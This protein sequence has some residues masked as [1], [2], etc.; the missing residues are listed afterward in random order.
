[1]SLRRALA[2]ALGAL[3]AG[4]AFAQVLAPQYPGG[5]K[6]QFDEDKP[7]EEQRSSLPAYPADRDLVRFEVGPTSAFD[8]FVD[9]TSVSVGK[10]GVVRYTLVARSPSGALNVSYEG[11]RCDARQRKLYAFG[12]SDKTWAQ[13]RNA[14]GVHIPDLQSAPGNHQ[15]VLADEFF[16]VRGSA[17]SADLAVRA[18][19]TASRRLP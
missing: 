5:Y 6:P 8:F 12:R 10:D 17:Q 1:M 4:T 2:A 9:S 19:K 3:C 7:W 14:D 13:A 15:A 18:L 11:I 16:C